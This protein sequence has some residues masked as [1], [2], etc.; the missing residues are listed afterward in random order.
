MCGVVLRAGSKTQSVN[1]SADAYRIAA[2]E[3]F[4]RDRLRAP[5]RPL[6]GAVELVLR[7]PWRGV[8]AIAEDLGSSTRSL[9]R[10]FLDRVGCAPKTF[11]R[12]A[13]FQRALALRETYPQWRWAR[14]A[15]ESGYYDQAH[16]IA[17]FRQF[18]GMTP[19]L[20]HDDLTEMEMLFLRAR[21]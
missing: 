4:L 20:H 1:A 18:S 9:E 7:E 15:V 21:R 8:A 3:R 13:R 2:A 14:V 17:D 10:A 19:A 6:R 12:I 5:D 16:L 11:A